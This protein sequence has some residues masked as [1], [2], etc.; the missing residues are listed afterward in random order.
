MSFLPLP[1]QCRLS[2]AE[3]DE[4]AEALNTLTTRHR[5]PEAYRLICNL[6]L[7]DAKTVALRAGYSVIGTSGRDT[8]SNNTKHWQHLQEQIAEHAR[9]GTMPAHHSYPDRVA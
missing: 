8:R 3:H 9:A 6:G 5:L 7:A 2:T 1:S 4:L